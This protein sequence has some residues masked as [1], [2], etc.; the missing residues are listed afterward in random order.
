MLNAATVATFFAGVT[1]EVAHL[2]SKVPLLTVSPKKATALQYS[3]VDVE[4]TIGSAVQTLWFSSLVLSIGSAVTS[5]L[6]LTWRQA[7]LWVLSYYTIENSDL[8]F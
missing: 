2:L 5:L 6:V 3:G 4:T 8:H 1:G 7:V